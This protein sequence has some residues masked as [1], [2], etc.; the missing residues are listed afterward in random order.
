MAFA[1]PVANEE[2]DMEE[3]A[4]VLVKLSLKELNTLRNVIA[5]SYNIHL[6]IT[7]ETWHE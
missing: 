3:L 2:D 4:E 1:I 7:L 5:K 6:H